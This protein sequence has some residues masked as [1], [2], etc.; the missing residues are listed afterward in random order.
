[1]RRVLAVFAFLAILG[2]A[3]GEAHA[4]PLDYIPLDILQNANV[5]GEAPLTGPEATT[6][7]LMWLD[8]GTGPN[9]LTQDVNMEFL[10]S[11]TENGPYVDLVTYGSSGRPINSPALF[12]LS[13]ARGGAQSAIGGNI[14]ATYGHIP[15]YCYE[16]IFTD[17]IGTNYG[18]PGVVNP[19]PEGGHLGGSTN[20]VEIRA[21][22]GDFD[23][24]EAALAGG[25]YANKVNFT[26]FFANGIA[27]PSD[28]T[29]MPAL[30][31]RSVLAGDANLDGT[32]DIS[33]LSK[34]LTNYDKTS[35]A[36]AL[37]DFNNDGTVDISDLS[38]VLTNYDKSVGSSAA[39]LK[40]VPEPASIVMLAMLVTLYGVRAVVRYRHARAS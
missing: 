18:I 30:V 16:G 25:A 11:T 13:I 23:T 40:V 26:A 9:I 31:M 21:W 38:K 2:S 4:A 34:V 10:G 12:L 37:G 28:L 15:G 22:T 1:M 36:W 39:G 29:D 8:T 7:G 35:M 32:V 27:F 33:D 3:A 5:Y 17:P 24:W 14:I 6:G 19:P 20:W